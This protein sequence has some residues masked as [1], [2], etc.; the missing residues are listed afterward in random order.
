MATLFRACCEGT[1]VEKTLGTYAE[2]WKA[3]AEG[4]RPRRRTI[5]L[6]GDLFALKHQLEAE[7][8]AK[9]HKLVWGIGIS[10]WKLR[11]DGKPFEFE[12]PLLTQ[13][14][15]ITLDESSMALEL[16]PRATDTQVELSALVTCQVGGAAEVD[17]AIRAH[18]QR[19]KDRPV[20]PFDASSYA[21]VLKLAAGSLEN[22]GAY[23][24]VLTSGQPLPPAGEHLAVTDAWALFARPRSNN[25]LHEDLRRLQDTLASGCEI[26][27]GP[28]ALVTPPA[29][30]PVLFEAINFRGLSGRG[31]SSSGTPP[32]ELY[33][34]LPYNRVRSSVGR[35]RRDAPIGKR[36]R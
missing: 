36:H 18:L 13:A 11:F 16:R 19:N 17:G 15:E 32:Q 28:A 22:H 35:T 9:P 27:D 3:W 12:Y 2:L 34:P 26:P 20:T 4:E 21:D 25:Y 14:M 10:T 6:Y 5:A 23:L 30:E 24:E 33:F 31:T 29:D 1:S 8:T 7:E